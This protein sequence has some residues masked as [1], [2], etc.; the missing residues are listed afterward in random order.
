MG[1]LVCLYL[2]V[3]GIQVRLVPGK[4]LAQELKIP[5]SCHCLAIG[6]FGYKIINKG[7]YQPDG[8]PRV[9]GC[10][11]YNE[12]VILAVA[13]YQYFEPLF[14]IF[15]KHLFRYP[16]IRL[17]QQPQFFYHLLQHIPACEAVGQVFHLLIGA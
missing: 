13:F 12:L 16:F 8:L 2:S 3:I 17:A 14:N 4:L 9:L 10:I 7:I 1:L 15:F 11:R 5:F 6:L